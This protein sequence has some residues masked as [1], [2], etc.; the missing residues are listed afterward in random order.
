MSS[1]KQI[2]VSV[3]SFQTVTLSEDQVNQLVIDTLYEAGGLHDEH[4][5]EDGKLKEWIEYRHGSPS[6]TVVRDLTESDRVVFDAISL[7]RN[8]AKR[9]KAEREYKSPERLQEEIQILQAQLDATQEKV[10]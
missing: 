3:T 9:K 8:A 2:K 1:S 10:A 4:F 6:R 7:I 5:P